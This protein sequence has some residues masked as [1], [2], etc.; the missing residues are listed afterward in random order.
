MTD[1]ADL[2]KRLRGIAE[3]TDARATIL[4][5]WNTPTGDPDWKPMGPSDTLADLLLSTADALAAQA[6]ELAIHVETNVKLAALTDQQ[7]AALSSLRAEVLEAAA[8][9]FEGDELGRQDYCK[10][11]DLR[12]KCLSRADASGE[13]N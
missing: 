13:E 1:Y 3:S 2:E 9:I 8:A 10:L 11:S 5:R 4:V 6:R 7:V 12:A